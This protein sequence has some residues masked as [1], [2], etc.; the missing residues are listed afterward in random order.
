MTAISAEQAER[1]KAFLIESSPLIEKYT[2]KT[3]PDCTDVCCRQKHGLYQPR[4]LAYLTALGAA[5]PVRDAL[6]SPE[7]PCEAMGLHGCVHPRWM[8]P[9]KCTWYFCEPL[10]AALDAG[11]Q[12]QARQ[13]NSAMQ[14]MI[15]LYQSIVP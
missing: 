2:A 13:L 7:G 15:D 1:L 5:V 9:F 11:P 3:C 12:K 8:R 14:E 10:L 6:R 4:D